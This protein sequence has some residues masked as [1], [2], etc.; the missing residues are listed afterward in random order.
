MFHLVLAKDDVE[1]NGAVFFGLPQSGPR[2]PNVCSFLECL[3]ELQIVGRHDHGDGLSV[4]LDNKP[5]A[6]VLRATKQ[7]RK[8]ALGAGDGHSCHAHIMVI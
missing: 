2:V 6:T 1:R 3:Q 5:L 4:P 8:L 7:I